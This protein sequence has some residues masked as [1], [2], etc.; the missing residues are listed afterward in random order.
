MAT[1]LIKTEPSTYSFADLVR[2]G[3]CTW[4]GVSNNTALI[5][6]RSMKPGDDVFIYHTGDERAI[7]GL[8]RV[9]GDPVQDPA[10][11]G[12]NAKGEPRF[13]VVTL[14]P[15]R[16]APKPVE[17]ETVKKDKQ[18]AAFPLVAQGRLSV[19]PVDAKS[20]AAIRVLAGL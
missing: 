15:V 10:R 4:D 16:A 9:V 20:D 6:L 18:F 5:H 2:D 17:L 14:Q 19:M 13:A 7:V 12:T 8:A 3:S 11:P 1:F